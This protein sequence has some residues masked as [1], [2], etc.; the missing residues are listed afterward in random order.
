MDDHGATRPASGD[1]R[2][3]QR[4]TG[5]TGE[6]TF[7]R[8][9]TTGGMTVLRWWGLSLALVLLAC[10]GGPA[11]P[12]PTGELPRLQVTSDAFAPGE[13]IPAD[14]TCDGA[15]RSPP[16]A[17]SGLPPGTAALVLIV[18]DPD[19]SGGLFTHWL[20]YDL[21][22]DTQELPSGVAPEPRLPNGAKQGRNDFGTLGYRGPCPPPGRAHRYIFRLYALDRTTGLGP[23]ARRG[24]VLRAVEGHVLATG[25]LTGQ[26]GRSQ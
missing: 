3:H 13:R 23:G 4:L 1:R 7:R 26:Y 8:T 2:R 11:R 24:E 20:L 6:R 10:A 14:F 16:L 12:S 25:E 18:E 17:W 5:L 9:V 21:P 15:D 22:P 19:A